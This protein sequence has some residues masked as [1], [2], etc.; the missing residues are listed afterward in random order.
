MKLEELMK[1]LEG[2]LGLLL[3]YH[4]VQPPSTDMA[5]PVT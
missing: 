5:V 1:K 4:A 3:F 2:Y